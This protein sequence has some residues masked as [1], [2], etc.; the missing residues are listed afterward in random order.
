MKVLLRRLPMTTIA[1]LMHQV[2]LGMAYLQK[3]KFVHRDLR[4][5]NV[6]LASEQQA[7]ISGFGMSKELG[8]DDQHYKVTMSGSASGKLVTSQLSFFVSRSPDRG[9]AGYC[10]R[11]RACVCVSVRMCNH[12]LLKVSA[13]L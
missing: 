13:K 11:L 6:L 7:K 1:S 9:A 4:A 3:M 5:H 2:A 12:F 10:T 8:F